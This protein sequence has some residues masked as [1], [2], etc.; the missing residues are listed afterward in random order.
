MKRPIMT[1]RRI[2]I[3]SVVLGVFLALLLGIGVVASGL[4][5]ELTRGGGIP[6]GWFEE[7]T[8]GGT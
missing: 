1:P 5:G 6:G 3:G 7:P 8:H 4:F 2:K